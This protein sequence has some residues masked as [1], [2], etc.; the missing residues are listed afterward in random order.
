MAAQMAVGHLEKNA[1]T[2]AEKQQVAC[3]KIAGKM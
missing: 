1:V 3:W 2:L